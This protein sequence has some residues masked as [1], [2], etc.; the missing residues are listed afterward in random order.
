MV[1]S[2]S[3][4]SSGGGLNVGVV[5]DELFLGHVPQGTHPERPERLAAASRALAEN[6]LR[7]RASLLPT[8]KAQGEELGRV[9]SAG[10]L[11]DLERLVPGRTGWLD[12]DTY[13]SPGSWSA[14]LAAAAGAV[15]LTRASVDGRL[16]RGLALVR[17]PGHHATHDRAMGFCMVNNVAVAAAA[18]RAAGLARVAIVDW[19]VHHGNGTQDIFW[20]DPDV[21]FISTHQYPFYPGSGA[22]GE[23]GAGAGVG[24]TVNVPLPEGSGDAEYRAAFDEIVVPVLHGFRPEM[25]FVSAGFDTFV[26]DPLAGMNVTRAGFQSMAQAIRRVA[27]TV[28]AGRLVCVLEGGYD[29]A[30]TAAGVVATFEALASPAVPETL[31]PAA[32]STILAGARHNIETTKRAL[33]PYH[34]F[35]ARMP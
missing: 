2:A 12:E 5:I 15:D 9:H 20:K 26:D 34:S 32:P 24:A 4:S 14:V 30:G 10:Y 31:A 21:L 25:I 8:R 19:D 29:L 22:S 16:A 23:I 28:C 18:A 27:D 3:S 17:P 1:S 33:A 11:A 35:P 7:E 6:G 13:F